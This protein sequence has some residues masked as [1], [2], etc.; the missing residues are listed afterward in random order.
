MK[1]YMFLLAL[2]FSI[3]S[4]LIPASV[5]AADQQTIAPDDS[6]QKVQ[7]EKGM[8]ERLGKIGKQLDG[9][10]AKTAVLT[11]QAGKDMKRYVSEAEKKGKAATVKL[12]KMRKASE[13]KWK[14]F[15]KGLDA[16][17]DD[18]EQAYEKAKGHF[19]E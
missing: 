16:A 9:L 2:A 4:W 14:K 3:A 13:K 17:A 19:K 5:G 6:Q 11:E 18:F 7:Y 15:T 1:R 12:E 10:K 8:E